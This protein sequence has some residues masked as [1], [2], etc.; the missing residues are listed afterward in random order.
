ML[1]L[2]TGER[3]IIIIPKMTSPARNQISE[4]LNRAIKSAKRIADIIEIFDNA[5][6]FH[7]FLA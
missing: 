1:Q 4:I 6:H 3:C 5:I 7:A 2:S